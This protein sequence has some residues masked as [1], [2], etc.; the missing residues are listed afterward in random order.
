MRRT[1]GRFSAQKPP[2]F[3]AKKARMTR[4][5]ALILCAIVALSVAA[6]VMVERRRPSPDTAIS[7]MQRTLPQRLDARHVAMGDPVY[8]RI[9]KQEQLLELWMKPKDQWV[10]FQTYDICHYSGGLGPKLE[11]GDKQAP[12]GFY[13]VARDQLNPFSRHHRAF[14]LGFPNA[15]DRAHGRTGSYLM[16][17]GGCT[18]AGCYAMTDAQVDDI[19][20]LVNAA[21]QKGQV[22]VDVHA[23]PFRM[24]ARNMSE[25]QSSRWAGFW[26]DL[27]RG[28]DA[29]EAHRAVP[30]VRVAGDRYVVDG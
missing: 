8:I 22:K 13:T 9:F 2:S 29:F 30:A 3:A 10:L 21:L 11:T 14:N 20:R 26:A 28:Y 25:H 27:K 16:V 17:H 4:L 19:Y 15:F 1:A 6:T 23:F 5:V 18:S 24:T 12:E 7:E